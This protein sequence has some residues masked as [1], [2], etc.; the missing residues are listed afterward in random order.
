M[1]KGYVDSMLSVTLVVQF[2]G[3]FLIGCHCETESLYRKTNRE[4]VRMKF[5]F[6]IIAA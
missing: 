1:A 5:F 6:Y 4:Y 3:Q 2:F